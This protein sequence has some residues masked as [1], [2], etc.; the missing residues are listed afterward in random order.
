MEESQDPPV[1]AS[2]LKLAAQDFPLARHG[3]DVRGVTRLRLGD[4]VHPG[5]IVLFTVSLLLFVLAITL[6]KEGARNVAPLVRNHLATTNSYNCLGYGWLLAYIIMGGSPVAATALAFFDAGVISKSGAFVMISGS[7]LGA[8]FIVLLLG[9]LYVLRGRNRKNSLSMGLLAL[10]ITASTYVPALFL[11]TAVLHTG[12]LD[13]LQMRSGALLNSVVDLCFQPVVAVVTGFLPGWMVFA[14]G[15][16]V[17][18]L[19]FN[20]FDRCLPAMTL[21]G[22]QMGR[23]SRLADRTW[24]MFIL[25]A[26]VT[27]ISMSVSLSLSILVPL[28]NRGYFRR[29]NAIPYIMGANIT[30]FIDTLL[31][32]VLLNN[33]AAFTVVLV[34]MFSISLVSMIILFTFYRHYERGMLAFVSKIASDNRNLALFMIVI[35]LLP[36]LLIL[37]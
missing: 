12:M 25:G 19:S 9:F 4:R 17:I 26:A 34:E 21:R 20:C 27:M 15:L 5:K 1:I 31:A 7:R 36:I 29:E 6:M 33:P 24:V 16:G 22:N 13:R 28:A 32:A 23:M 14:V 11:G 37:T 30:T 3:P 10:T 2:A 8:S 18:L 35:F